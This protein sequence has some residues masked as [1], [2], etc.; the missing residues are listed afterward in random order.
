MAKTST[1]GADLVDSGCELLGVSVVADGD[2]VGVMAQDPSYRETTG[3]DSRTLAN[4][5]RS[6]E[7]ATFTFGSH[8]I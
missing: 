8:P 1:G 5:D 4:P 6:A 2:V 7:I 3:L